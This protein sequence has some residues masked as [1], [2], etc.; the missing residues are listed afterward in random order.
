M[1]DKVLERSGEGRA[2]GYDLDAAKARSLS[3]KRA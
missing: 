2:S 1:R 3:L